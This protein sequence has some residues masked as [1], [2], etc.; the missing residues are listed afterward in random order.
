MN[1]TSYLLG[2]RAALLL[3]GVLASLS[4]CSNDSGTATPDDS[5][6]PSDT[7]LQVSLPNP[8]LTPAP[9]PAD[10][11]EV[12]PGEFNTVTGFTV[13]RDT[14]E[15]LPDEITVEL[16]EAD[17]LA[18]P[19]PPVLQV[20]ADV[21]QS[22]NAIPYFEDLEDQVAIAGQVLEV[23]YRPID[24]D[25][26]I[27]GMFPKKLLR[28]A[29][30]RDNFNGSKS[31]IWLPLQTDVGIHEFTVTAIDPGNA[32]YRT[33]RTIRIKVIMPEDA[34]SI[35]NVAPEFVEF[36][37]HTVRVNDPVVL[38]LKATDPNGAV[39][40]IEVPDLPVGATL[41][42]HPRYEEIAVL[43]FIPTSAGTT[44]IDVL[45]RDADDASLSSTTTIDITVLDAVDF[46]R[47]GARLRALAAQRDLPIG[48]AARREFYHLPDGALYAGIAAEEFNV[49]TSEN[50]LNM[51]VI[52]PLPGRY[53]FADIDNL[54]SYARTHDMQVHGSAL[55]WHQQLPEWMLNSNPSDRRGH[56]QEYIHRVLGRYVDDVS[57]WALV[58]EAIGENGGMRDSIWFQA[59]GEDYIE[60][61]FRQARMTHP[62]ATLLLNDF[63]IAIDGPKADT[64]YPLLDRLL[65]KDV[66]V[67]GV[68]FQLHIWS[69]FDQFDEVRTNFQKVADLGLEI[70]V[71]ELDVSIPALG[72]S[73]DQAEVYRQIL[74]ICL[75]Q[76]ACRSLKSWGF[77]DRY[78][79]RGQYAPLMFDDSYQYKPAYEALQGEL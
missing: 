31:L 53:Q 40:L 29:E 19:L 27:P 76:P 45:A 64:L 55:I 24:P 58:N 33:E 79:W 34:S 9:T 4:A 78:S 68:G 70:H 7:P 15:R 25:G 14:G 8:P 48:F 62:G 51:D 26:G 10:E 63:D 54:I 49:V 65:A 44:S 61:A 52:N 75:E 28:N 77:T 20:P 42:Q 39:P 35:P 60:I 69:D 41:V 46:V 59:M 5:V 12:E 18:G 43:R 57:V 36:L 66:P 16:T 47:P 67:D 30:F 1:S 17:F 3:A 13:V 50:T 73:S 71:T 32:L 37:P 72:N 74:S 23:L 22:V 56:M 21:D 6:D 38:E 2:R 11:P